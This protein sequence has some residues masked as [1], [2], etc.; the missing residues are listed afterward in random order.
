MLPVK[1]WTLFHWNR[2]K[3]TFCYIFLHLQSSQ[4]GQ[5]SNMKGALC[6][7]LWKVGARA[8]VPHVLPNSYLPT[9]VL[10]LLISQWVLLASLA[11]LLIPFYK[12]FKICI[13]TL[14]PR[15]KLPWKH[16]ILPSDALITSIAGA[17]SNGHVLTYWTF[18]IYIL[19][20]YLYTVLYFSLLLLPSLVLRV[21]SRLANCAL[22]SIWEVY[23]CICS[24]DW[25]IW[26]LEKAKIKWAYRNGQV[27]K[28]L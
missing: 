21:I 6:Q 23:N 14:M 17:I 25:T 2:W 7:S 27:P 10:S 18:N 16:Q 15:T 28:K 11:H 5:S 9:P 20:H 3:C 4:E 22:P 1:Y 12:C 8:P 19:H 24:I 13:L 26:S